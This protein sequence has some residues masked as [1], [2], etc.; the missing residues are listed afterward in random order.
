MNIPDQIKLIDAE[1]IRLILAGEFELV[2]V[3]KFETTIKCDEFN[4]KFWMCGGERS[5]CSVTE[6]DILNRDAVTREYGIRNLSNKEELY[7]IISALKDPEKE[8]DQ[9]KEDRAK[10]ELLKK[11]FEK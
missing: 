9:L 7:R 4:I 3:E 8:A 1:F 2:A 5:F 6:W 11:K 10:Y